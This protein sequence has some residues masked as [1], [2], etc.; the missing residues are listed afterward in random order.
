M[1]SIIRR[2]RGLIGVSVM[3]VL[4]E[5]GLN[6]QSSDSSPHAVTVPPIAPGTRL[7]AAL[8]RESGL[9][10]RRQAV[11]GQATADGRLSTEPVWKRHEIAPAADSALGESALES[12]SLGLWG[13]DD[14]SVHR[15]RRSHA[16]DA[17][18]AQ[19]GR[20]CQRGEPGSG[21]RGLHRGVGP[22]RLGIF[23]DDAGGDRPAGLSSLGAVEDLPL[24]LSQPRAVEP[25]PGAGDP[26]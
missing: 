5:V 19:L 16:A 1:S 25:A 23:G 12:R 18:A 20:L 8:Y 24:R 9:V 2:R 10:P 26:A 4:P 7:R 11:I 22:C 13:L 17:A 21:D 3:G 14:A 6:T 15:W